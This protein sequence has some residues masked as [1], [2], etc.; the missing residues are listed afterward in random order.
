MSIVEDIQ[1]PAIDKL[2]QSSLES[3]HKLEWISCSDTTDLK[4]TQID[5]VYYAIQMDKIMLLL[6][7][8]ETCTQTYVDEFTRMYALPTYKYYNSSV[9]SQFRRYSKWLENRNY[10][11]KGF[12]KHDDKYYMVADEEFYHCYIRYGFC[13]ACGILRCSPVWCICGNKQ[14]CDRWTSDN[15]Q[16]DGLIKKTQLQT[17]SANDAYLEWIPYNCINAKRYGVYLHGLPTSNYVD[18]KLIPLEIHD[19]HCAEVNYLLM[20]HVC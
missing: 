4:P 6:G 3:K 14:L 20:R 18:V 16:L 10:M 12:T 15:P 9:D 8:D 19:L 7:S 1:N 13:T 11:I 2:I 17:S 5:N